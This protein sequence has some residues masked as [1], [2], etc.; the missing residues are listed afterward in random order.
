MSLYYPGF[1]FR[2]FSVGNVVREKGIWGKEV[3]NRLHRGIVRNQQVR[4][5]HLLV[6]TRETLEKY[7][8]VTPR[9]SV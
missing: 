7:A 3:E 2:V 6:A 4:D 8:G 1:H 9:F 5:K